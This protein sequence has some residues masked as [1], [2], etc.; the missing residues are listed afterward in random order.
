MTN[1]VTREDLKGIPVGGSRVFALNSAKAC[2]S[3]KA[4]AYQMQNILGCKFK[5]A[6]DYSKN[7]IQIARE[8]L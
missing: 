7:E 2:D 8:A 3:A 6:T 4:T 1:R 5:I